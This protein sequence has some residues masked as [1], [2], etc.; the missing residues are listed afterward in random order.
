MY[1]MLQ[2]TSAYISGKRRYIGR[3]DTIYYNTD[4]RP[5]F[6]ESY[7]TKDSVDKRPPA[8]HV[9]DIRV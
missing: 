1:E 3:H 5:Q 6:G 7:K 8:V 2:Q 4:T 9:T